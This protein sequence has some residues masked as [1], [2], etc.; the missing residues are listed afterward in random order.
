MTSCNRLETRQDN[1]T[2][3]IS[4]LEGDTVQA[5]IAMHMTETQTPPL[6]DQSMYR[7]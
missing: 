2:A 7:R 5:L 1:P 6:K 4:V 3:F